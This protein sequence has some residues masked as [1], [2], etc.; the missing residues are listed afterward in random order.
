MSDARRMQ[1]QKKSGA[2][3][4]ITILVLLIIIAGSLLA[5]KIMQ[6]KEIEES[7][8]KANTTENE[9]QQPKQEEK[10]EPKLLREMK[11]QLLL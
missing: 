3:I 7:I 4:L 10:K 5:I 8:G 6:N 2:K 1:K 9:T 11:D